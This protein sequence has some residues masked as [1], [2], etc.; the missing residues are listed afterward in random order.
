MKS[1]VIR[2]PLSLRLVAMLLGKT[3]PRVRTLIKEDGL[4][5]VGVPGERGPVTKIF[6]TPLLRWIN[7]HASGQ[8]MTM[9]DLEE[10]LTRCAL[11]I[12]EQD[13][14]KSSNKGSKSLREVSHAG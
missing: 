7:S 11:A 4:P 2:G 3:E 14:A 10:E 5:T 8:P 9:D 6:A 13:R 12:Q 1:T